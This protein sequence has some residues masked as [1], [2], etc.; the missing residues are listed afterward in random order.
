MCCVCSVASIVS[1][2]LQPMDYSS[3][4]SSVHGIL[5]ARILEW[6][7]VPSS[8]GSSSLRNPTLTSGVSC[9]AGRFFTHWA[10]WDAHFYT[11][12]IMEYLNTWCI[13]L[14]SREPQPAA[15]GHCALCVLPWPSSA[16]LLSMQ[17]KVCWVKR[18]WPR[19]LKPPTTNMVP[20]F[21]TP[22]APDSF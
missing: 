16:V 22:L 13:L 14:H 1:D 19:A 15:M 21:P 2:S 8:R 17:W 9:T 18:A 20:R 11:Y 7:A 5:Q 10:T 4:G 6:V 12:L 3:P